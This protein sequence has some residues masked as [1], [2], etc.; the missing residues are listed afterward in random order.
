VA[1]VG[2]RHGLGSESEGGEKNQGANAHHKIMKRTEL[3]SCSGGVKER[4]GEGEAEKP[5]GHPPARGGSVRNEPGRVRRKEASPER[6]LSA[7][8][9]KM[10]GRY[11]AQ[12]S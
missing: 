11:A 9:S 8:D 1:G 6:N 5:K 4:T 2:P 12:R 3:A 7:C 10:N